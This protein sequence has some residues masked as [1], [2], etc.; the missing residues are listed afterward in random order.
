MTT[1]FPRTPDALTADWLGGVIR[2]PV[3]EF[4]VESLGEGIGVLGA[5]RRVRLSAGADPHSLIIKFSTPVPENRAVALTYDMYRR[6]VHFYREL[7]PRVP[8]RTPRC[9]AAEYDDASDDFV[10][11]LE[12]LRDCRQGDQVT[13]ASLGDAEAVIDTL[14]AL[15]A[16]TWDQPI[17]GV[18]THNIPA[19]REGI[20]GG[21]R[22][23]WPAVAARFPELISDQARAR[24]PA[25][26]ERIGGLIDR[27]TADK[28]CLVHADVRLD[29]IL[30]DGDRPVL[31][32]WQSVCLCSGEQDLAYFLT[33]SLPDGLREA[34]LDA[35][36]RRYHSALCAAG[37]RN[38]S[39]SE[40]RERFRIAALY[41][42]AWAVL[43][44]GTLD[45]GNE[46]GLALARALLGRSL[47]S[48]AGLDGFSLLD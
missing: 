48:V 36:V 45:M 40:C 33:Q 14:A 27:L 3:A 6:E 42:L 37:V 23:G 26:A 25:L 39:L 8:I 30:F 17:A 19:Q 2:Q 38:H 29:N 11:V 4:R 18:P 46:R 15:H 12:D 21:F 22:Q 41:L 34:H 28:Q 13:G 9:L 16:A 1:P 5:V 24:V 7:A 32:D 10:L 20:A 47:N 44:A 43:I 35:L 31:V